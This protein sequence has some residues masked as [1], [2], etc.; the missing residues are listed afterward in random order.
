MLEP[1]GDTQKRIKVIWLS[2]AVLLIVLILLVVLNPPS[3]SDSSTIDVSILTYESG[4][5]GGIY[6]ETYWD[7]FGSLFWFTLGVANFDTEFLTL[8]FLLEFVVRMAVYGW[9]FRPTDSAIIIYNY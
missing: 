5:C 3:G 2:L 8:E 1:A 9:R 4:G 7:A 6:S